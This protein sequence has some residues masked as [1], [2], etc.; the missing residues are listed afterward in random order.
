MN[1]SHKNAMRSLRIYCADDLRERASR[2]VPK[3]VFDFIDGGAEQEIAKTRNRRS[4]DAAV[5]VPR[6]GTREGAADSYDIYGETFQ[7]PFGIAPMGLAEL[8]CPGADVALARAAAHMKLPYVCSAA[9]CTAVE[10]IIKQSGSV[11]WF[12]MY[13]PRDTNAMPSIL[14][15]IEALNVSVLVVTVDTPAPG[16]RLRDLRN[17]FALPLKI[18]PRLIWQSLR[19]PRWLQGRLRARPIDF[20]NLKSV[21]VPGGRIPFHELMSAQTGG[22]ADWAAL[23]W[24]RDQWRGKLVLKGVLSSLDAEHARKL[25]VDGIIVSNHGGR[26]FDAAPSSLDALGWIHPIMCG[27]P[28]ML[29]SGIRSGT[30]ILKALAAGCDLT[31]VGRPFLYALAALGLDGPAELARVFI[32]EYRLAVK[33]Y[34]IG[35][36][37]EVAR[38]KRAPDV[39]PRHERHDRPG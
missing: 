9:A 28:L 19:S 23:T 36:H 20:P 26:Q 37:C 25:G 24:V 38:A 29:D 13:I 33:L 31:F 6:I 11:P 15:R 4:F 27:T 21:S 16:R 3:F 14:R 32:D 39:F 35:L 30:D 17:D 2:R 7:V 34:G 12:Q 22:R 10:E 5:L 18:G 1:T 8:V